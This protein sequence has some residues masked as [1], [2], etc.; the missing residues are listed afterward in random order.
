MAACRRAV[1]LLCACAALAAAAPQHPGPPAAPRPLIVTVTDERGFLVDDLTA[2]AFEVSDGGLPAPVVSFEARDVPVSVH[3]LVD[4]SSSMG[5]ERNT[6]G[7]AP[8]MRNALLRFLRGSH[9]SGEF[10]LVAFNQ[11]PQLLLDRSTDPAAVLSALDRFGSARPKG[12]TALFDALYLAL[13]RAASDRYPKRAILLITDGEDNS[14]T[15]T[16]KDVRRALGQSDV[17]VYIVGVVE[18][19]SD[20]F[21]DG[22]G[23]TRRLILRELAEL[24]GGRVVFVAG[25]DDMY[26][27]MESIAL[28]LRYQYTLGIAAPPPAGS[29]GWHEI[30]VKL[31]EVRDARGRKLKMR[32]RARKGFYEAA[33][34]R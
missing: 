11:R 8:G 24:S 3:I 19:A 26:E 20:F 31:N 5:G 28:E 22:P 2:G 33:R 18:S 30:K 9:E 13:A 15:Y 10:S 25:L 34:G 6:A 7:S 14:S 1:T 16:Y 17:L 32:A 21:I 23:Q 27:V 29:D 4:A 12:Q